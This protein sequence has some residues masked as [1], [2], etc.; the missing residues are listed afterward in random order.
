MVAKPFSP[1]HSV[2]SSTRRQSAGMRK[3]PPTQARDIAPEFLPRR[4]PPREIP[5]PFAP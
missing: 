2:G 5:K 4:R 1:D 3:C